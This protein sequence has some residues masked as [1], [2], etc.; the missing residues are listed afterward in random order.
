VSEKPKIT[1][2]GNTFD[3]TELDIFKP[4]QKDITG[5]ES[6]DIERLMTSEVCID[7]QWDRPRLQKGQLVRIQGV[8]CRIVE[9]SC[10]DN[11]EWLELKVEKV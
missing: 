11:D 1:I 3:V 9:A 7:F 2:T 10:H 8:L 6:L 5:F 4:I